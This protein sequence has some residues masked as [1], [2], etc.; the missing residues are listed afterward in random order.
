MRCFITG[1]MLLWI[2]TA[3]GAEGVSFKPGQ[4]WPDDNGVHINAHGGGILLYAGT[5]YWFGEH[6]TAGRRG[7][8]AN[9]GVHCYSSTD[10]YHWRD[11]GVAL[12]VSDDP[13]SVIF[14]GC[15][16]ERPKVIHNAKTGKFVMWFHLELIGQGYEAARTGLAV[17]DKV[18]GPYRFIESLRPNAGC[19]PENLP[20]AQR[21]GAADEQAL[22]RNSEPW[23]RQA[24][25]GLFVRRDFEGGQMSRDMTLFVDDDGKAYHIHASEENQTLHISQLSDDYLSFSGRY[26]R[27][28]P[29]GHNEAPAVF[30]RRGKYY[31]ISSG[32][33]GWAPNAARLAVADSI[34]GPWK[35]LGNPC[36]GVN[37]QNGMGPEKT[38]GGQSTF[39]LPVAGTPD[40]YVALF[41]LWRPRDAIDGRYLWLPIRFTPEGIRIEW[42]GEWDLSVF[43]DPPSEYELVWSDEF[44]A[45][46][47]PDPN[48]WTY[49]RG[50]VRNEELQWYQPD[51]AFC[52]DGLLIIEG[53]RE[54]KANP[55]YAAGSRSWQR[56]REYA[57][58]TSSSLLTR[59]LHSWRYGRF[60]IRA[61]FD[62]RAGLWPAFWT[63]GVADRWPACGEIDIL[64]YYRRRL[65]FNVAWASP[66]G[67]RP[68]WSKIDK[69]IS[70]F[71]GP[72]WPRAF[73][74]WRMD[75]DEQSI[76]LYLDDVLQITTDLQ[77]TVNPPGSRIANPFHQPH[78]ILVNLAIGGASGG[79]PS[80]TEFPARYE[81]DYIRVYQKQAGDQ[82]AT[83]L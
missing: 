14:R 54:R 6:K 2:S 50:F 55:A 64:E 45:D 75:W 18:T 43:A 69:P 35:S 39:V 13:Q 36:V 48:N 77:R 83:G 27:V 31:L 22:E 81:I 49:E 30:K 34:W 65:Y 21:T 53:R 66:A 51:N 11:E 58:Y 73:H 7:N 72:E 10:L 1:M 74:L 12:G 44:D 46:G 78:Y 19:W 32:C 67:G 24:A 38:F 23:R 15:I 16:I 79:D 52:R 25:A 8:R 71:G 5:Y 47:R 26:V 29:G 28:L 41:D 20:A 37:P 61:R 40:A 63:L 33:T 68:I 60:E 3:G 56:R 80:G 57:E 9:V 59:G 42:L 76:R 82:T 4:I 70:D 17:S 62:A